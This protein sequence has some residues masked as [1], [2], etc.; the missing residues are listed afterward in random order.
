MRPLIPAP[1]FARP[2]TEEEYGRF[3]K[4]YEQSELAKGRRRPTPAEV[5]E[6]KKEALAELEQARN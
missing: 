5:E 1:Q 6:M 4:D 3:M 2:L